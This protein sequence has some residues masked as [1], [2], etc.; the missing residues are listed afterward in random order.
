MIFFLFSLDGGGG[1]GGKQICQAWN[2]AQK[3]FISIKKFFILGYTS[4]SCGSEHSLLK[5]QWRFK[6]HKFHEV[7]HPSPC[8]TIRPSLTELFE[9]LICS[10]SLKTNRT[11]KKDLNF[12]A[13]KT[14]ILQ[15]HVPLWKYYSNYLILRW[16]TQ[17]NF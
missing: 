13:I 11:D 8:Q 7:P 3:S 16:K 10:Y 15:R 1:C 17:T 14:E 12:H 6:Y 9:D 5:N 2:I 4:C